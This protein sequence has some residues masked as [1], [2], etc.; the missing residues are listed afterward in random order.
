VKYG[1]YRRTTQ[2]LPARGGQAQNN[3]EPF[4]V[5]LC[6]TRRSGGFRVVLRASEASMSRIGKHPIPIPQGV[7]VAVEHSLVVAQ[8][9]KGKLATPLPPELGAHTDGTVLMVMPK[10]SVT[11]RTKSLW[12]LTRM[13]IA[14]AIAGVHSGFSKTLLLEGIGIRAQLEGTALVLSL[15]FSHP[16]RV[17]PP[18]NI[19]FSVEK[20]AVVVSGPDKQ[21]VGQVAAKI[22]S[23][24]KPEP[25]KGAGI[26]YADEHVRRKPGK[27][28]AAVMK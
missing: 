23:M 5:V 27:K 8:G 2:N 12:G 11:K 4:R 20:N 6:G 14:N 9:P 3:A 19:S 13:Q 17:E 28:A 1:N 24:K 16:M 10:G 7:T 15:G 22:R 21:L 18:E 26:H 25:Y